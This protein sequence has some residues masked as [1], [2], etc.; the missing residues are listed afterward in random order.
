LWSESNPSRSDRVR[1]LYRLRLYDPRFPRPHHP[2]FNL[3]WAFFDPTIVSFGVND[4][5]DFESFLR[6]LNRPGGFRSA[7]SFDEFVRGFQVFDKEQTGYITAGE[8]KYGKR[9]VNPKMTITVLTSLGEKLTED[10]VDELL[11]IIHVSKDGRIDYHGMAVPRISS[12][13]RFRQADSRGVILN[14]LATD[15]N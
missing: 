5:V 8:L 3:L 6:I 15:R 10:E 12:D 4:I 2:R 11:K 13:Y 1:G 7:G 14:L 9:L